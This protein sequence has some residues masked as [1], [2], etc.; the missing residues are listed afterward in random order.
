MELQKA[1]EGKPA[2]SE[3]APAAG[4]ETPPPAAEGATVV[5]P[6]PKKGNGK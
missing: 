4:G 3:S 6:K 1:V 5:D 2:S